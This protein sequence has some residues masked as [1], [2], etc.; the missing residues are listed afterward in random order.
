MLLKYIPSDVI[1]FQINGPFFYGVTD[2]LDDVLLNATKPTKAF[3]LRLDKTPLIDS[4]GFRALQLFAVKCQGL[5]INFLLSDVDEHQRELLHNTGVT[6]SIGEDQIFT[7][8]DAAL[9]KVR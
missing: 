2:I 4:S 6:N 7:T 5:G 3:I 9:K 1:V 8:F